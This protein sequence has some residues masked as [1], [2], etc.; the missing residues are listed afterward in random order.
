MPNI[1]YLSQKKR[2]GFRIRSF[3]REHITAL[4]RDVKIYISNEDT[5]PAHAL[6]MSLEEAT[7]QKLWNLKRQLRIPSNSE[8]FIGIDQFHVSGKKTLVFHETFDNPTEEIISF[9]HKHS[10]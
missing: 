3:T 9:D 6:E 7:K 4:L 10:I 2:E 1:V 5:L 8:A